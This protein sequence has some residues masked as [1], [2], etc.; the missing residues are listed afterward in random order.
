M[1]LEAISKL[2]LSEKQQEPIEINGRS[3]KEI[4]DQI[5]KE[6]NEEFV[7]NVNPIYLEVGMNESVA[8]YPLTEFELGIIKGGV[9][10]AMKKGANIPNGVALSRIM[11]DERMK[12]HMMIAMGLLPKDHPMAHPNMKN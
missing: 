6:C 8:E 3:A 1:N 10:G 4:I 5:V 9:E 2:E 11:M 7:N 12:A